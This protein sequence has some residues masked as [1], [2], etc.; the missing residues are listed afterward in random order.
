MP[1]TEPFLSIHELT[2][3]AQPTPK[4]KATLTI[5]FWEGAE[6]IEIIFGEDE[7]PQLNPKDLSRGIAES[8]YPFKEPMTFSAIE[9]FFINKRS[10][11]TSL[12]DITRIGC[13]ESKTFYQVT[14]DIATK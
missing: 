10:I 14:F 5:G 11:A 3:A 2:K 7:A 9:D 13:S 8:I 12:T 6:A 4:D 1:D